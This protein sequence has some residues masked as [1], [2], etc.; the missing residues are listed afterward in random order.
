M[1]DNI[2]L[3]ELKRARA[4]YDSQSRP[5]ED[6]PHDELDHGICLDCGKDC[7]DDLVARAEYMA[8]A[9]EDR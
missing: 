3:Q 2:W 7:F 1:E 8:D 5:P 6:C 4:E 9:K